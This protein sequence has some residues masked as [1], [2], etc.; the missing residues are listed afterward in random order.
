[1]CAIWDCCW[2]RDGATKARNEAGT[3]HHRNRNLQIEPT[4]TQ[5]NWEKSFNLV[6]KMYHTVANIM[7]PVATAG[8]RRGLSKCPSKRATIGVIIAMRIAP[9]SPTVPTA[10]IIVRLTSMPIIY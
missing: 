7:L 2:G 4:T 5:M 9:N 6:W 3:A 1:M 10:N 8:A